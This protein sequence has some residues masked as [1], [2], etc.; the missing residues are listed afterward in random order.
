MPER[1]TPRCGKPGRLCYRG[2]P[3]DSFSKRKINMK[4]WLT[5]V[6]AVLILSGSSAQAQ[7]G[8]DGPMAKLHQSLVALHEQYNT[9]LAQSAGAAF[10]SA[11][12]LVRLIGD[13]VVV[14]V[15]A[16]GDVEVLKA[17]LVSLGMEN[18]V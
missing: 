2:C 15:V 10:I 18:A 7:T 16:S 5:L 1:P 3:T 14:D 9:H 8:K 6:A 17:D 4:R 13:R 11:D 12:P